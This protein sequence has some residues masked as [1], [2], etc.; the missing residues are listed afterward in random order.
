MTSSPTALVTGATAG[1]GREFVEQLAASGHDL[2]LVARDAARLESVAAEVRARHGGAVEILA[3]DLTDRTELAKVEA[4]LADADRPV[5]LLINNA[6]FGLKERF[7]VNDIEAEQQMLDVLVVAVLRL[8]HAA[9]GAMVARR[10]GAIVNVSSVASFLPRG[11]YSAAKAWVNSFSE[12]AH[13]EYAADGVQVM[14]LCPGFVKTEFHQRME[15]SRDSAPGFLWLEAPALVSEALA[16]LDR[17]RRISI[18][19]K[20]YRAIVR[21]ARIVPTGLLQRAQSLGRR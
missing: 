11:T 10:H 14:A 7:L 16:D 1:I 9:L 5:D 18:P 17:G 8:S 3:A 19:S 21:A 13:A 20:R 2:I 12:W 6:G 15:V 4:R